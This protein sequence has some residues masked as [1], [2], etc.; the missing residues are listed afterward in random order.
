[1]LLICCT[2]IAAIFSRLILILLEWGL[3]WQSQQ[4][5]TSQQGLTKFRQSE[6][7]GFVSHSSGVGYVCKTAV[8]GY[9]D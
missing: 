6:T 9:T 7:S 2:V 1:M 3:P 5:L 8:M 4:Y